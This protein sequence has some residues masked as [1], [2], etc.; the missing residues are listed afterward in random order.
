MAVPAQ[1]GRPALDR[2]GNL[3][4][5]LWVNRA[6]EVASWAAALAAVAVLALVIASVAVKGLSSISWDFL[7]QNTVAFGPGGGIA[8]AIVGTAILVG[9]ATLMAVPVGILVAIYTSEFASMR[10]QSAI[11]YVLDV[12]NGVPTIVTGI[13][14]FGLL[15]A[16]HQQ[17]GWAG[18]V[19]LAIVMLPLV[20]RSCHEVLTL[21]PASLKEAGMALGGS[22]W[23]TIVTVIVPTALSGMLT[24]ALL[25]VARA[26]GETAPLLFT[27]SIFPPILQTSPTQALPNIPVTIFQFS[28]APEPAKHAQAWAAALVLIAFV[29]VIS[30]GAR[31]LSARTRKRLAAAR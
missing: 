7:T 19:G 29:L 8:N 30:V 10:S 18:S 15:V 22:R 16:G 31:I 24:S 27:T 9:L 3:R 13:F 25:A 20:A 28:E 26:A 1:P 12:L 5:R 4:R 6:V 21:V 23:R 2:A 17:S 11:R 14:V